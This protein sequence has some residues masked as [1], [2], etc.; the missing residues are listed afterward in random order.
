M[1]PIDAQ[2]PEPV[3]VTTDNAG[4]PRRIVWRARRFQVTDTPTALVGTADWWRPFDPYTFGVGHPPLCIAG[5]RF[6]ATSDD[7]ETHVFDVRHAAE[8]DDWVLLRTFD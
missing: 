8:D 4:E 6:Q 5:W 1:V 2:H 7:G 3:R